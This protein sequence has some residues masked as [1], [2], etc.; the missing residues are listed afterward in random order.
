[1]FSR[2]TSFV[3][4][5]AAAEPCRIEV[6]LSPHGLPTMGIVGL[7]DAAV[8]ES[9][10]RVRTSVRRAGFAWPASRLTVNLAP[11]DRRKEGPVYDLP[12]A[13]GTLVCAGAVTP[14]REGG[15]TPDRWVMAG[16]LA[17]DGSVRPVRGIVAMAAMARRLGADGVVVPVANEAEAALVEGLEVVGVSHLQEVVSFLSGGGLRR[18]ARGTRADAWSPSDEA[19]HAIRGQPAATRV[20]TLAAAGGHNL[21]LVGPPGCG[22][23]ML[24]RA[25]AGVL[26]PLGSEA[27]LEVAAVRSAAGLPVEA[28]TLHRPPFRSPH[29][30]SSPASLVG[31]G[32]VPRPG[33][34][35]LAHRGVLL[36]DEFAEFSRSA[37]DALREPLEDGR[38]TISRASGAVCFPAGVLAIATFNPVRGREAWDPSAGCRRMLDRIGAP[39]IDRFDLHLVM[40]PT[41]L[42]Q[43]L[44]PPDHA[45]SG[46]ATARRI[47]DARRRAVDRQQVANADLAGRL[48]DTVA[49]LADP[50]RDHL[51]RSAEELG[52]SARALDR[53]RRVARTIADLEG[54]RRVRREHLDEALSYRVLDRA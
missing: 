15:R 22:K 1:M 37:I 28:E 25:I 4:V 40:R 43:M 36:L 38:V 8:R 48:L 30:T 6:D 41:P 23:T 17:L 33:E 52:L 42:R 3:L 54:E 50:V 44:M 24:A 51:L 14:I 49:S 19:L 7:P 13:V 45:G 46:V 31:G 34:V 39:I 16:E 35:S 32:S 2:T 18:S 9:A 47:M 27:A 53:V 20:A 5:G 11:A 12:I 29:H 10:E 21:I 26:P